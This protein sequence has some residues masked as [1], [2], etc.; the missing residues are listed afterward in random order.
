MMQLEQGQL[1]SIRCDDVPWQPSAL[2]KGM[3]VKNIAVAGGLEMQL[4]RME[5]GTRIALHTHELPEFIYV[6]EGEL[7][8]AG[9]LLG[10]GWAS[11]A[12]PGSEHSDVQSA[13][14]CTF[15]LVDRPL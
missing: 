15:I 14:G 12:A 5:P 6:L 7:Q 4:V 10:P 3:L 11:I 2:T 8:L 13:K 1:F 9:Q